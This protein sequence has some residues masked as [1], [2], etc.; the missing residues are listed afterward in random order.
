MHIFQAKKTDV[1]I[2]SIIRKYKYDVQS[3]REEIIG[4]YM[5]GRDYDTNI[6][7]FQ[8]FINIAYAN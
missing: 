4:R 1:P 6:F 8:F 5:V 2:S 3:A 7:N